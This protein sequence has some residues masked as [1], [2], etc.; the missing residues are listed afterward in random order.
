MK[1]IVITILTV[2]F[3]GGLVSSL[4]GCASSDGRYFETTR[5]NKPHTFRNRIYNPADYRY[6]AGNP[7]D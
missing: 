5:Q 2:C 7:T 4:A 6:A 3:L 1:R